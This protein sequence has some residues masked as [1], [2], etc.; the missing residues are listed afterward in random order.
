MGAEAT[1]QM[2]EWEGWS[3]GGGELFE[4]VCMAVGLGNTNWFWWGEVCQGA[5]EEVEEEEEGVW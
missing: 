2:G 4:N 5:E 3:D 1:V